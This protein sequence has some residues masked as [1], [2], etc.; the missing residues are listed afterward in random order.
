MENKQRNEVLAVKHI[1]ISPSFE[2][3]RLLREIEVLRSLKHPCIVRIIGYSLPTEKGCREARIATEFMSNG[4][5]EDVLSRV[6]RGDVPEFW[7][8]QNITKMMIGLV[9]GMKYLHSRNIIHRDLKPANILI[10]EKGQIRIADFGTAKLEDCG[11]TSTNVVGTLSFMASETLEGGQSTKKSDVFAF[12]LILYEVLVGERVFPKTGNLVQ[13]IQMHTQET[14]PPIPKGIHLSIATLIRQCWT[15]NPE[16]RPTFE[17]I[18]T[19]L[20]ESWFALFRDV[21][22][23]ECERFVAELQPLK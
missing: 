9:L 10:D 23:S 21:D 18:L 5:L 20:E 22:Y 15:K 12:G 16:S 19:I 1:G 14:R 8:H 13:L 11:T 17:D 2:S 6:K 4:S 3:D 7:S